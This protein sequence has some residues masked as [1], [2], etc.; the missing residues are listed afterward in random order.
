M[1]TMRDVLEL[2]D[3]FCTSTK[4]TAERKRKRDEEEAEEAFQALC[5]KPRSERT[6]ALCVPGIAQVLFSFVEVT[7]EW[8]GLASVCIAF[9][10][11]WMC[12][13]PQMVRL[14]THYVIPMLRLAQAESVILRSWSSADRVGQLL[15][16]APNA[17]NVVLRRDSYGN[18]SSDFTFTSSTTI[19]YEGGGSVCC[20]FPNTTITSLQLVSAMNESIDSID[21]RIFLNVPNLTSLHIEGMQQ[22][23]T[24]F[25]TSIGSSG[26]LAKLKRLV[27]IAPRDWNLSLRRIMIDGPMDYVEIDGAC[28]G[29]GKVVVTEK[30][31][32][33]TLC[34]QISGKCDPCLWSGT[35]PK[36]LLVISRGVTTTDTTTPRLDNECRLR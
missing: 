12:I 5:K 16:R 18:R 21:T 27:L 17:R 23:F 13:K 25:V 9:Y 22:P 7:R 20:T 11:R 28:G 34:F 1:A 10:A 4:R 33:D 32:V 29:G 35:L 8:T 26:P 19:E 15:D 6:H 24:T 14:G 2:I 30:G 31:S 36:R 3:P